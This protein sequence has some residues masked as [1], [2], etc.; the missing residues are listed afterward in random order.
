MV[1][2]EIDVSLKLIGLLFGNWDYYRWVD[3]FLSTLD[4]QVSFERFLE[5]VRWPAI[6]AL[7]RCR[8]VGEGQ[9][10]ATDG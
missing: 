5:K 9:Q 7:L 1:F 4:D 6:G 10:G 3:S 8:R 2:V